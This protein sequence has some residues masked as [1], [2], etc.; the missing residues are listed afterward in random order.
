MKKK[1]IF[2]RIWETICKLLHFGCRKANDL[3][4]LEEQLKIKRREL[5]EARE[6]ILNGE[7]L[8]KARGLKEKTEKDLLE[9]K[10]QR[11]KNNYDNIIKQLMKNGD[12]E[13]AKKVLIKKK[14]EDDRIE[15][16]KEKLKQLSESDNTLQ[17]QLDLLDEQIEELDMLLRQ[18]QERVVDSQQRDEMFELMNEVNSLTNG[19]D[20]EMDDIMRQVDELETKSLGR[21]AEYNR[22]NSSA[23]AQREAS[24]SSLDSELDKYM[25]NK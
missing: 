15:R 13:Q 25:D 9:A 5:F 11:S 2:K 7:T 16:L 10:R 12:R 6:N 21:Q 19:K 4:P 20:A 14:D 17:K 3:I 24:L 22:R 18:T 8:A 1:S 23:L